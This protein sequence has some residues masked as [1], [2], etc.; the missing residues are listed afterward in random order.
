[1]RLP[2]PR[3]IEEGFNDFLIKLKASTPESQAA[4]S[5][6]ASIE[7]CLRANFG[8]LRFT[9]IGSFGNGT[10]I[11]GYS[12]VDYLAA[13]PR[14]QL[15]ESS[16][17]SLGKVRGALDF[18]FPHT[19]VHIN[20]PAVVAPFGSRRAETTEVV[21]ADFLGVESGYKVYE[22][23]DGER[24]WMR[25]S[26]DAHNAYVAKVDAMHNGRVKP[27]IRF[28]KAWKFLRSVPISSFYVEMR[29]ARYA[30][31]ERSIIFD[32][33]MKRVLAELCGHELAMMRDPM[34]FSGYIAACKTEAMRQ[35]AL[36]KL[37]TAAVRADKAVA[38][39]LNGHV[40]DAF[41]W[42]RLLYGSNFP[43]YYY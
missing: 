13:I 16:A 19:G 37:N 32:I 36:S 15:T 6:R 14:Q 23:A 29:V 25:V 7:S 39:R 3:T 4:A 33:D 35:D 11:S 34:G 28:V 43:T 12:D 24:G 2:M 9:R 30:E 8:L 40:D 1:M 41:E 5:H 38:A 22:I 26:P 20:T 31:T 10:S 27:L 42:W 21:P 17:Y 18:R